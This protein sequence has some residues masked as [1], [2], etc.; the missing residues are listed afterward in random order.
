MRVDQK[1]IKNGFLLF[2]TDLKNNLKKIRKKIIT[3]FNN[4]SK[5]NGSSHQE[6]IL[7]LIFLTKNKN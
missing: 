4:S 7:L 6:L 5:K 2:E 1:Y 3:I